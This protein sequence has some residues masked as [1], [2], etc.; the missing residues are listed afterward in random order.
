MAKKIV[1]GHEYPKLNE[2]GTLEHNVQ[3]K[4][5]E[6]RLTPKASSTGAEGTIFYDSDDNHVYV[7]TE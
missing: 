4:A 2:D 3:V 6:I 1:P 5:S 7:G